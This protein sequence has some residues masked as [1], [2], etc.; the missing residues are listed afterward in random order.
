[1][2]LRPLG[3]SGLM[4]SEVGLGCEHL[5]GK[6]YEEIKPVIDAA[7]SGGINILDVFMPNPEVRENI[8]K[9]LRGQRDK[10]LLQGHI[11]V[12]WLDGQ[13]ARRRDRAFYT[14]FFDDFMQRLETDYVDIGMLH[15]IDTEKEL[16]DALADG[17]LE[18]AVELKQKGV[19]RSI[20]LSSHDAGTATKLIE[21][22]K[23]DVLMFS[24]NPAFDALPADVKLDEMFQPGTYSDKENLA[25]VPERQKLYQ[26]CEALGVGITVMKGLGAGALLKAETSA[27]GVALTVPQLIHYALTRPAVAS[28]LVGC[29]TPE[30][31]EA[32]LA[33]EG[34][35]DAAHDYAAALKRSPKF[36]MTGRCMYC[37]HCLPCPSRIDIAKVN[38]YLDMAELPGETPASVRAHYTEMDAAGADCIECGACEERCPFGVPVI[39]KMRRAAEVFGR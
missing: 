11:G 9:A 24:I 23:I 15:F 17:M 5:E 29:R 10:V 1:M 12:G 22:G 13:Y 2:N 28:V 35:D 37:N 39:E 36:G 30:E 14:R 18:Y 31:V 20:G 33:Y 19:I 3:K 25:I 21:T 8:G 34:L 4:A 27:Y 26:R 32:A 38:K 16:E 6:P 7:I